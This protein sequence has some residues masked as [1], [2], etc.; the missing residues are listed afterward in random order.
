MKRLAASVSAIAVAL[1]AVL[2]AP[3]PA[4]SDQATA[5]ISD[6]TGDVFRPTGVSKKETSDVTKLGIAYDKHT[7][8]VTWWFEN[9]R[10]GTVK[11]FSVSL[12]VAKYRVEYELAKQPG[13]GAGLY[14]TTA[15][16]TS[17]GFAAAVPDDAVCG[18][19]IEKK[20]GKNGRY[21]VS[22]DRSCLVPTGGSGKAK[23]LLSELASIGIND[24]GTGWT[25]DQAALLV[26]SPDT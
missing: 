25:D 5:T 23:T 6:P 7:V 9:L 2:L 24:P 19:E 1:A 17:R 21:R 10:K 3:L 12:Y 26:G 11:H 13:M 15:L 16:R 8:T 14:L 18:A 4:Q 22:F 20:N